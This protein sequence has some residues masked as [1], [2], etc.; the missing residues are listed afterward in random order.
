MF[1]MIQIQEKANSR[2]EI[3]PG[4]FGE[5][6]VQAKEKKNNEASSSSLASVEG[7]HGGPS[8]RLVIHGKTFVTR[9]KT[10]KKKPVQEGDL[11]IDKDWV[12]C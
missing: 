1:N 5:R 11:E 4:K 12:V 6:L 10:R 9:M 7:L 2:M 3:N 8:T